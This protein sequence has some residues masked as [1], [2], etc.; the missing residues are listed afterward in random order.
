MY[1]TP[2]FRDLIVRGVLN[3]LYSDGLCGSVANARGDEENRGVKMV[4]LVVEF[5]LV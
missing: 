1:S 4:K 2:D 3:K 5:P